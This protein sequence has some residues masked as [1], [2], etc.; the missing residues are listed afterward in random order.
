MLSLAAFLILNL[1]SHV[2]RL[3][4]FRL[5]R[6]D[7]ATLLWQ[8][9]LQ[10]IAYVNYASNF[11]LYAVLSQSFRTAASWRL[12]RAR[13]AMLQM[14]CRCCQVVASGRSVVSSSRQMD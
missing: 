14:L 1:P 5:G 11:Y 2:I 12:H 13:Q 7:E 8:H 9:A 4:L 3:H 6:S 10:L